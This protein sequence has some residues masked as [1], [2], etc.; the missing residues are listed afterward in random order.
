MAE[1]DLLTGDC[2]GCICYLSQLVVLHSACA[3]G[4]G[5]L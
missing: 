1:I 3:R 4:P 5:W 2:L